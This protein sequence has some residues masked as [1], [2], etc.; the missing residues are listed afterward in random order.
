MIHKLSITR[1]EN[2]NSVNPD[3]GRYSCNNCLSTGFNRSD[4]SVFHPCFVC[5]GH[6][7]INW[8]DNITN[9]ERRKDISRETHRACCLNNVIESVTLLRDALASLDIDLKFKMK[10]ENE[11]GIKDTQIILDI[12]ERY[13]MIQYHT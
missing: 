9:S 12:L 7:H 10:G 4:L 3:K 6:G 8:V 1:E 5:A 11:S 13:D 2:I